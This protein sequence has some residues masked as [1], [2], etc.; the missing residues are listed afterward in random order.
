M[1]ARIDVAHDSVMPELFTYDDVPVSTVSFDASAGWAS[2]PRQL[3]VDWAALVT[4]VA[5]VIAPDFSPP[6]LPD[7]IVFNHETITSDGPYGSDA[8]FYYLAY[9]SIETAGHS[10]HFEYGRQGED[11]PLGLETRGLADNV[12]A[13]LPAKLNGR[14]LARIF[15]WHT[16]AQ[17]AAVRSALGL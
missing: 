7:P 15:V 8:N 16:E 12:F 17:R 5:R 2:I 14:P 1:A 10:I 6:P 3:L 11:E 4:R 13:W 9:Y